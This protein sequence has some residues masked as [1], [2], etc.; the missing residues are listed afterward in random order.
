MKKRSSS[1]SG[2]L[3]EIWKD[4]PPLSQACR[5]SLVWNADAVANLRKHEWSIFHACLSSVGAL[6]YQ[7][8]FTVYASAVKKRSTI[9]TFSYNIHALTLTQAEPLFLEL[10]LAPECP[11][12]FERDRHT[13]AH[14]VLFGTLQWQ[15]RY[16]LCS[17]GFLSLASALVTLK[18]PRCQ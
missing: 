12:H 9:S 6:S 5:A 18:A 8:Q 3:A 7:K 1:D 14:C 17:Q 13:L 16:I 2:S 15:L 10:Q 4:A 11:T